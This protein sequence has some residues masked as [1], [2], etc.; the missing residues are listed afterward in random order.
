MLF[1]KRV[2]L[3]YILNN[4]ISSFNLIDVRAPIEFKEDN[5]P[6]S[7]NIPL[8]NDEER[9]IVGTIYK[10]KGSSEAKLKA[11]DLVSPKLPDIIRK[12]KKAIENGKETIIYCWRGG[13]RS[14]TMAALAK[15]AGLNVNKLTGGYKVFRKHVFNFFNERLANNYKPILIILYG[16]TGSAKT[17]ILQE[18][19]NINYPVLNIEN[20]ACHKG[21]SFGFIGE[22]E[23][24]NITQK[25]FESKLWYS[26]Y[27]NK[28]P[29][30]LITEGESKKI[31]KVTIPDSLFKLFKNGISILMEP[32]FE[33][34]VNYTLKTYLPYTDKSSVLTALNHIKKYLGTKNVEL[35]FNYFEKKHFYDFVNLLLKNYYDPLYK[36][37]F[38]KKVDYKVSYNSIDEGVKSVKE[39]IDL[40]LFSTNTANF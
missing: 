6:T 27:K 28:F 25:K 34:R 22:P 15:L 17:K 31:G 13:D 4:G 7:I 1:I 20:C 10:Q 5:I 11:V 40:Y 39:I 12:I 33:F 32:S 23:F 38:P 26:F 37:S 29:N 24:E 2:E 16:P 35:L 14:E 21:S 18:L 8:L 19:E 30:Y 3:D 36:K 9:S